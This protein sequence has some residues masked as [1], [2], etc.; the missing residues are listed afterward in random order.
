MFL[1][2]AISF[3]LSVFS[4]AVMMY[5]SMATPIGPWIA[6]TV[7]LCAMLI[8]KMLHQSIH[9]RSTLYIT[10]ASSVG[11]IL[12]TGIGFSLP[13]LYFL[14]PALFMVRMAHPFSFVMYVAGIAGAAG[15]F[16]LLLANA[17][18]QS[19][20]VDQNL[21]F[22]IGQLVHK[23]IVAGNQIRKAYEMILGFFS[24]TI[25][26]LLQDGFAYCA[27][28][29]PKAVTVVSK[30][31]F[32][33]VHIPGIQFDLWPMVWAIG[34]ITG[35][36]I[37]VPLGVGALLKI[38][39]VDPVNELFFADFSS[40]EFVFVLCSGMALFSVVHSCMGLPKLFKQLASYCSSYKTAVTHTRIFGNLNSL[41][42]Y[43]ETALLLVVACGM[44]TFFDFSWIQQIYLLS[45]T[46][47]F[48]YQMAVIA[49]K[50]GIAPLGRFATFV[51]LPAMAL[52]Q[53]SVEQIVLVAT[54]VE[55]C[56][57]VTVDMLCNRK[58]AQLMHCEDVKVRWYQ[59]LG[60][61][62]S[63]ATVG[64]IFW[65][66]ANAC[67]L[68]S[69]QLFAYKAQS[70]QLLINALMHGNN[71]NY[72]IMMIGF[73][74]SVILQYVKINPMLVLGGLLM[75]L[76]LSIGLISGGLLT[77]LTRNKQEWEPF[78]SG[79][80]AANSVW[81]IIKALL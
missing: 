63:V 70:R 46:A 40:I 33:V 56:G 4:T 74:L 77:L 3:I 21:A 17:F 11:G 43:V 7:V 68:G 13:T 8:G 28:V 45:C 36:V 60:L 29:I 24:T 38:F 52:F 58:V 75:P 51:M 65:V 69:V 6:P 78:W 16:G 39:F 2:I 18:E 66:L 20:L 48:T 22:P 26:C 1:S 37:A 12:A 23:M 80:F 47:V 27:G 30:M 72:A 55:V 67:G 54:F 10:S 15:F 79:V 35:H 32:G 71:F 53:M 57:G 81:M 49:G 59:Y 61:L 25:F 73:V 14:D 5:I 50:W 34:F 9:G 64:I 44:L 76:N 41:N 19:L 42:Y 31:N 62:V